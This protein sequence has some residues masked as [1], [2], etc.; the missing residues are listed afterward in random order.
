MKR[1]KCGGGFSETAKCTKG[2]MRV[3]LP[4]GVYLY[5]F[6]SRKPSEPAIGRK[7]A[8]AGKKMVAFFLVSFRVFKVV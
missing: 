7:N 6:W 3:E 8:F 2:G 5:G 4:E 1:E